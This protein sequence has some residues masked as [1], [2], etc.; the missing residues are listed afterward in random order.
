VAADSVS[1]RLERNGFDMMHLHALKIEPQGDFPE[2]SPSTVTVENVGRGLSS[3][4]PT[5]LDSGFGTSSD[6]Q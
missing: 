5:G 6:T 1:G 3:F 4:D 2:I